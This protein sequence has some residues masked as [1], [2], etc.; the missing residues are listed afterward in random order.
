L[1]TLPASV[2]SP[3]TGYYLPFTSGVT[4]L[5]SGVILT[6]ATSSAKA[7]VADNGV[8]ITGGSLGGSSAQGV[9]FLLPIT[10][11]FQAG[12]NLQNPTPTTMCVANDTQIPTVGNPGGKSPLAARVVYG[13]VGAQ[14]IITCAGGSTP[15]N[16]SGTPASFGI[17]ILAG[18]Y[19]EVDGWNNVA[20]FKMINAVSGTLAT[21]I[22]QVIYAG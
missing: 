1:V 17:P 8:I 9:L 10:G 20:T 4:G 12:E 19:F 2:I 22:L 14:T 6:G 21:V 3:P 11:T 16:A 7:Q 13:Y 15:T 5:A 18:S